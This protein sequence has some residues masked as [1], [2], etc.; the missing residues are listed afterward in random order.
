MGDP[1]TNSDARNRLANDLSIQELGRMK[2]VLFAVPILWL[3]GIWGLR[4]LF[5]YE[6]STSAAIVEAQ[7]SGLAFAGVILAVHLQRKEL[8]EQRKELILTRREMAMTRESITAGTVAQDKLQASSSEQARHQFLTAY[9]NALNARASLL[10]DTVSRI[11]PSGIE[12]F[13]T[14]ANPRWKDIADKLDSIIE[15]MEPEIKQV[16]QTRKAPTNGLTDQ[17]RLAHQALERIV[18]MI[19]RDTINQLSYGNEDAALVQKFQIEA[20]DHLPAKLDG[21]EDIADNLLSNETDLVF[22]RDELT[23]VIG[24]IKKLK[25]SDPRT[26]SPGQRW[27]DGYLLLE[28]QL[29]DV[30]SRLKSALA[31]AEQ[32]S[33]SS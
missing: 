4:L 32:R 3:L 33:P 8:V 29:V 21:L 22:S 30:E 7:F 14:K 28:P 15:Q 11:R 19:K 10:S 5:G 17:L 27:W 25:M 26:N 1:A 12:S 23:D 18:A 20:H 2:W 24:Q 9:I 6:E 31:H 13:T 16:I